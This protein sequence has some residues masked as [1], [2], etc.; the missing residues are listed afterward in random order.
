[1]GGR[2]PF[3]CLSIRRLPLLFFFFCLKENLL[4]WLVSLGDPTGPVHRQW[5]SSPGCP[6]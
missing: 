3:V 1:M 2:S 4:G 5:S 6:G